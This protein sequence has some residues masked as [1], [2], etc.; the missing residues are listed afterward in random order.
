MKSLPPGA[1]V[2]TSN[3]HF[4]DTTPCTIKM[5]R[6]AEFEVTVTKEGYKPYQ[7]HVTHKVATGGG[8]A[9]AGNVLIGGVIG[10][11]VDVATGSMMDLTPN[12]L[13][14]ELEAAD[15]PAGASS[16]STPASMPAMPIA[17]SPERSSVSPA[18]GY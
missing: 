10:A 11:G 15:A 3:G 7:G 2:K 16:Q 8:V 1:A 4:C 18:P 9:M 12:P 17:P 13:V 6:K 14:V 5:E